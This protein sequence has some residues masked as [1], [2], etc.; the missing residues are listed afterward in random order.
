M[1]D[2]EGLDKL[3]QNMIVTRLALDPKEHPALF[4]EP[5]WHCKDNRLKLTQYMF[6]KHQLPALFICKSSV[7]TAF[8]C[9][10]ST[11]LVLESGA[12]C[13]HAVPVHDGYA[14]QASLLRFDIGG[15]NLT[16]ELTKALETRGVKVVPRYAFVKKYVNKQLIVEYLMSDTTDQSYE[17]YCRSEIVRDMKETLFR[18]PIDMSLE[19]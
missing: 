13:T 7:L 14:L 19:A 4:T 9:G 15:N 11:A 10:R 16:E 6:E 12:N 2:Y 3:L 8:S 5:S 18:L 1:V 17:H